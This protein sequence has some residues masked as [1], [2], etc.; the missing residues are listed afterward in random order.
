VLQRILDFLG[1][2]LE[3][4]YGFRSLLAF[5]AKFQP[6]FHPMHLVFP[7]ETTLGEIGVAIVRA[8][9][10]DASAVDFAR[11]GVEMVGHR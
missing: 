2:T 11:M 6:E 7:D 4:A 1:D 3:P 5:K 9:L 10:P 8:Y